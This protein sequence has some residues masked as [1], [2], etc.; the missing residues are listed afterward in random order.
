MRMRKWIFAA[1]AVAFAI[2]FAGCPGGG[3]TPLP[4]EIPAFDPGATAPTNAV[5][6]LAHD[7]HIQGMD[8]GLIAEAD[9]P[10][11]GEEVDGPLGQWLRRGG[12]GWGTTLM[13]DSALVAQN[14]TF[15]RLAGRGADYH[16][17]DIRTLAQNNIENFEEHESHVITVWG[18]APAG[19]TVGLRRASNPWSAWAPD[20]G[21]ADNDITV[22]DSGR[23]MIR[24]TF[25]WEDLVAAPITGADDFQP[26]IRIGVGVQGNFP[27]SF[28]IF[29]ILVESA[30]IPAVCEC[31]IAGCDSDT[32]CA[33]ACTLCNCDAK[34]GTLADLITVNGFAPAWLGASILEGSSVLP[35]PLA[36]GTAGS[37]EWVVHN[38]S[39][40]LRVNGTGANWG[41][42]FTN[43][44]ANGFQEGDT[45]A[46]T[47]RVFG[48]AGP[49]NRAMVVV[50]TGAWGPATEQF[51][52][53]HSDPAGLSFS[54]APVAGGLTEGHITG[55][56]EIRVHNNTGA[57]PVTHFY[58]DSITITGSRVLPTD[59]ELA[60]AAIDVHDTWTAVTQT[61]TTNAAATLAA[62]LAQVQTQ[63]E[64][65]I[66]A[67]DADAIVAW[68]TAPAPTIDGLVAATYV[69]EVDIDGEDGSEESTTIEV[70]VT[71]LPTDARAAYA[72]IYA[73]SWYPVLQTWQA[74][75]AATLA[76]ALAAVQAQVEY[77]LYNAGI[78]AGVGV[79]WD[80]PPAPTDAGLAADDYEFDVAI[81]GED[82]TEASITIT[83]SVQFMEETTDDASAALALI[84]ATVSWTAVTQAWLPAGADATRNA[85]LA[86]V[87]ALVD[88]VIAAV[89]AYADVAWDAAPTP[90][91]AGIAAVNHVF[92]VDIDGE[93]GSEESTTI[94][95]SVTF[96]ASNAQAAYTAIGGHPA[97][98]AVD[99]V[100]DT[101]AATTLAAIL[102]QVQTQVNS[103]LYALPAT[104]TVTWV[105]E[106]PLTSA[107]LAAANHDFAVAI[108]GTDTTT[109][110]ATITVN[111]TV[112]ALL[113]GILGDFLEVVGQVPLADPILEGVTI[114]DAGVGPLRNSGVTS[115][116]SAFEG[117]LALNLPNRSQSWH[118]LD[119]LITGA[120]S[121]NLDTATYQY[122][123]TVQGRALS[124]NVSGA[125]LIMQRDG[126]NDAGEVGPRANFTPYGAFTLTGV[127][128]SGIP[129]IRI[130][131]GGHGAGA[132]PD[133][134]IDSI[135]FERGEVWPTAVEVF[136]LE[137]W[138]EENNAIAAPFSAR[139]NT[140]L[141]I[142]SGRIR[143][144]ETANGTD[145][146]HIALGG[147]GGLPVQVGDTVSVTIYAVTAHESVIHRRN[148]GWSR[149][150]G[151]P[152]MA[153]GASRT[154]SFTIVAADTDPEPGDG[155]VNVLV[156][157]SQFTI[158]S[159]N[160]FGT[161]EIT[162][163]T[164]SR[165]N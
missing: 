71:F 134:A 52:F 78:D 58:I 70:S 18:A 114:G 51:N 113:S 49:D 68:E 141:S 83:V 62:A 145:G 159:N 61:W 87:Q 13:R 74:T 22:P 150:G 142:E 111:V 115:I 26:A 75:E 99:M 106:P 151:N 72:A 65:V 66:G 6:S 129:R 138:L 163:L 76:A 54:L 64:A 12:S 37:V 146:L 15:L 122:T 118:A 125:A 14:A 82:G 104:G 157:D 89:D 165:T 57:T 148:E 45:V 90:V 81:T 44:A 29:Q 109:A 79:T 156:T 43:L 5:F 36:V 153:V 136:D 23:F 4:P 24:R 38:D 69:F 10:G 96:L 59:A 56:L 152:G 47:G 130:Q 155:A 100:W 144:E 34:E 27:P 94:E 98:T 67:I 117:N 154:V 128:G 11:S 16:T 3:T 147:A 33:C 40:S 1:A 17:I 102:T 63:V 137:G 126:D 160:A 46:V 77:E 20:V 7:A 119:V 127:I 85:A 91:E 86:Q 60:L 140:V 123:V 97:W 139:G 50:T 149:I 120:G 135:V 108:V 110:S 42:Q 30:G 35:A 41:P 103:V 107:G 143:V 93:D 55:G 131:S 2:A 48:G 80:S 31:P 112:T 164:V 53:G 73:A 101:N 92:A 28:D 121:L 19:T 9:W 124:D 133:F 105:A 84:D 32:P 88:A 25:T 95:V 21:D 132:I 162:E 161:F 8:M 158:R 116:W 39:F